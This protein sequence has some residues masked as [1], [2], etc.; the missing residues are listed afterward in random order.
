MIRVVIPSRPSVRW[1][2]NGIDYVNFVK[3]VS[4]IL[5]VHN[6]MGKATIFILSKHM[7]AG[8]FGWYTACVPR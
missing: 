3:V 4:L 1:L 5:Y 7:A 8:W 6:A 2:G